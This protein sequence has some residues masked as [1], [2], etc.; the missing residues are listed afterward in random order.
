MS[1]EGKESG[2]EGPLGMSGS[3]LGS[4]CSILS[5]ILS[6]SSS[7]DYL[8]IADVLPVEDNI[9]NAPSHVDGNDPSKMPQSSFPDQSLGQQGANVTGGAQNMQ[10]EP[11][12]GTVGNKSVN[13]NS[14]KQPMSC[15]IANAS[16]AQN[17]VQLFSVPS[18]D[19]FAVGGLPNE[20]HTREDG[21]S[22]GDAVDDCESSESEVPAKRRRLAKSKGRK[23][24]SLA[25]EAAAEPPNHVPK[26]K[27]KGVSCHK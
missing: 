27:Y 9:P 22:M 21:N 6:S 19:H 20:V 18:P 24:M 25:E 14:G 11:L 8:A 2:R 10:Q 17:I 1:G 23:R 5:S 26:S 12:S 3:S 13:K 4:L 16:L 7:T 15:G